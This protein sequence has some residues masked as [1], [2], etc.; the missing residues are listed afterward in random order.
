MQ[1]SGE[2]KGK[3]NLEDTVIDGNAVLKQILKK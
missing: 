2:G 1:D 3:S